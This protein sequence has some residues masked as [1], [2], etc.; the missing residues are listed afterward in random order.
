MAA[1]R[2]TKSG[3]HRK[4]NGG[5]GG[6]KPAA[7]VPAKSDPK[8]RQLSPAQAQQKGARDLLERYSPQV[9][10]LLQTDDPKRF[11]RTM[12]VALASTPKLAECTQA[13]LVG[14]MLE[15]ATLKLEP[16]GGLGECWLLPYWNNKAKPKPALEAQLIVGYRGFMK[17]ARNT[18]EVGAIQASI[19]REG[20]AFTYQLGSNTPILHTPATDYEGQQRDWIGVYAYAYLKGHPVPQVHYMTAEDVNRIR[21]MSQ[22]AAK[23]YGPW[24]DHEEA[25]WMKSAVRQLAKFLPMSSE[26]QRAVTIDGLGDAGVS[27]N[28]GAN[29]AIVGDFNAIEPDAGGGGDDGQGGGTGGGSPQNA[30]ANGAAS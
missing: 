2:S 28:L 12:F 23:G 10:D 8:T 9:A 7:N 14:S 1:R 30:N 25:M 22:A 29:L 21:A 26:M 11:L 15:I 27:Q 13:S 16:G 17:L 4:G 18:R 19:V 5:N 20:E 24:V 6:G 3:D